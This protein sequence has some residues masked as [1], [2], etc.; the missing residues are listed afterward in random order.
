L[1]L[2]RGTY[3][4]GQSRRRVLPVAREP[5]TNAGFLA[6]R[7]KV[8]KKPPTNRPP[9]ASLLHSV[10]RPFSFAGGTRRPSTEPTAGRGNFPAQPTT[11]TAT[12]SIELVGTIGKPS[13]TVDAE[14]AD[15]FSLRYSGAGDHH[16]P[17]E[18]PVSVS[19]SRTRSARKLTALKTASGMSDHSRSVRW[20][21][22]VPL[23]FRPPRLRHDG[24]H[25]RTYL[26]F[27]RPDFVTHLPLFTA[28]LQAYLFFVAAYEWTCCLYERPNPR[29]C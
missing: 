5:Y 6:S 1:F 16:W 28:R 23:V 9:E 14:S 25:R 24:A 19:A 13:A 22:V 26:H 12:Q 20:P 3:G 27:T 10:A 15:R 21:L 8:S 4:A 7:R 17:R 11:N 2:L 18:L 29:P